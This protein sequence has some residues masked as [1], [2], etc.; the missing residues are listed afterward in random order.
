MPI[1]E[2]RLPFRLL[3]CSIAEPHAQSSNY[4]KL[5]R[6]FIAFIVTLIETLDDQGALRRKGTISIRNEESTSG[7]NNNTKPL[8]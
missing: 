6:Y 1:I 5:A 7:I 2:P 4:L 3:K 8:L